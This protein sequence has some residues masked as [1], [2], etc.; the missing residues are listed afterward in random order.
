MKLEVYMQILKIA[1]V[2]IVLASA[3]SELSYKS[4][5]RNRKSSVYLAIPR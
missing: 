4:F 5:N 2:I 1:G 3:S